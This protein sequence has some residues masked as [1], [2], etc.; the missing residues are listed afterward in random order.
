MVVSRENFYLINLVSW[1]L[2]LIEGG[3][4]GKTTNKT[5]GGD[6]SDV[7]RSELF[8]KAKSIQNGYYHAEAPPRPPQ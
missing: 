2:P 8:F 3:D 1:P 5:K 6:L 4:W 7:G